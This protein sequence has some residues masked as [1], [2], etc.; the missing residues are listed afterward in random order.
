METSSPTGAS[1]AIQQPPAQELML[2]DGWRARVTADALEL[3]KADP[4][5]SRHLPR[6]EALQLVERVGLRF[7]QPF[8]VV[9]KPNRRAIK[10]STNEAAVID[11]WLGN[12]FRPEVD[13]QLRN[14]MSSAI[15]FGLFYFIS[16]RYDWTTWTFGGLLLAEGLFFRFRPTYWLLLLDLVFWIALVARNAI[17]F[18]TDPGVLSAVFGMLSLVMISVSLRTFRVLRAAQRRPLPQAGGVPPQ[19]GDT[20]SAAAL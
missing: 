3:V 12:D 15:P 20:P 13:H 5:E 17:T 10:M 16:D 11:A 8:L 9:R 19:P 6:A 2:K 18:A 4:P 1:A 7:P 14:R